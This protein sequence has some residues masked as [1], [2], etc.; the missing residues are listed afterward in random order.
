MSRALRVASLCAALLL[1]AGSSPAEAGGWHRG[2]HGYGWRG[3]AVFVGPGFW[4]GPP[5]WWYGAPPYYTYPGP[6]IVR[7]PPVYIERG[8]AP[9][10]PEVY[11]YY[12]EST[13]D[14]YPSVPACPEPWVKI[15]PRPE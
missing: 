11:W 2:W 5:W 3:P 14:Y 1:V 12:C 6:V 15:P 7:E 9:P 13:G 10:T 8:P 4:W